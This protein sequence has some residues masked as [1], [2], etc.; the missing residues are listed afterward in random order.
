MEALQ[1]ITDQVLDL[2]DETEAM[3]KKSKAEQK[4]AM[5]KMEEFAEKLRTEL[6]DELEAAKTTQ[7]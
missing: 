1:E 6:K 3:L 4:K 7:K 5:Q 2:K